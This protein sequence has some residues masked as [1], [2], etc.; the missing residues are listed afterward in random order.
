MLFRSVGI[1][2]KIN[3]SQ[4]KSLKDLEAGGATIGFGVGP[5]FDNITQGTGYRDLTKALRE[6]KYLG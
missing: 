5:T 1:H 6:H 4:L 2:S 3:K